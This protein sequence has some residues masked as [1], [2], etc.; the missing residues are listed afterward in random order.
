[1]LKGGAGALFTRTEVDPRF[2]PPLFHPPPAKKQRGLMEP[3]KHALTGVRVFERA[4][5]ADGSWIF[6][7]MKKIIK[8]L[9]IRMPLF[10]LTCSI[11]VLSSHHILSLSPKIVSS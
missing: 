8:L 3:D 1:M 2:A 6:G 5:G 10:L 7:T 4:L 11:Y 9:Q